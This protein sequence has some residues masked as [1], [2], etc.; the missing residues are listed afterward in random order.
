MGIAAQSLSAADGVMAGER[1]QIH[2]FVFEN[3]V[4][5][6]R[7]VIRLAANAIQQ[8]DGAHPRV[9]RMDVQVAFHRLPE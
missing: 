3:G 5:F 7:M 6:Q 9:N 8:G 2:A 1:D 4:D